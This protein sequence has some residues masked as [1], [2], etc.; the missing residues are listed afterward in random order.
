MHMRLVRLAQKAARSQRNLRAMSDEPAFVKRKLALTIGF[1]GTRYH[2]L[3]QMLA[4]DDAVAP[5][6]PGDAPT[7]RATAAHPTIEDELERALLAVGAIKDGALPARRPR[8]ARLVAR[9][10]HRPR[11]LG[12]A[13]RRLGQDARARACVPSRRTSRAS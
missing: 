6:T 8:Q 2:G 10:A 7:A 3:Q 11:R 12:R 5:A 4:D 9:A 1:V 13:A